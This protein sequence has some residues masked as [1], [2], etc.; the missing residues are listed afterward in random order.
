[1][2]VNGVS[3]GGVWFVFRVLMCVSLYVYMRVAVISYVIP[4]CCYCVM[5]VSF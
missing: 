3:N 4:V 5:S 1:M 2:V